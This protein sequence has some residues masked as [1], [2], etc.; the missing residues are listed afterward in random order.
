MVTQ[1]LAILPALGLGAILL[2]GPG[3]ANWGAPP[4]SL[5]EKTQ[6]AVE[7]TDNAT[8]LA[9]GKL[10]RSGGRAGGTTS[11]STR[12]DGELVQPLRAGGQGDYGLP[13]SRVGARRQGQSVETVTPQVYV[14]ELPPG[15]SR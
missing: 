10:R 2:S 8:R 12:P 13:T 1:Y 4:P 6:P 3:L 15:P 7:A 5:G 14:R 11:G 9:E